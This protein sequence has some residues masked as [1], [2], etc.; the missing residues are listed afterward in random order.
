[1]EYTDIA[2]DETSVTPI[3][4]PEIEEKPLTFDQALEL[5]RQNR[6]DLQEILIDIE[7]RGIE[8]SYA[9]NQLLP[10]LNLQASYWSP[11]IS[12]TQIMYENN[13]PTTG[14][15]IGTIPGGS[16]NALKV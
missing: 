6:P 8:L 5:A 12:G 4:K 7:N 13:D 10:D 3:D 1:M 16:S 14:N 15:V 2:K 9:K 11:G